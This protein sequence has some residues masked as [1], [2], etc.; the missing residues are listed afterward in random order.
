M[1]TI[2]CLQLL[3]TLSKLCLKWYKNAENNWSP[4]TYCVNISSQHKCIKYHR[5]FMASKA[6]LTSITN[7]VELRCV[8]NEKQLPPP[9]S[10]MIWPSSRATLVCLCNIRS[11]V[12]SG[13]WNRKVHLTIIHWNTSSCYSSV[14][15]SSVGRAR[16]CHRCIAGLIPGIDMWDGNGH[17]VEQG[18]CFLSLCF[19]GVTDHT[20]STVMSLTGRK[21]EERPPEQKQLVLCSI[22]ER[23]HKCL[24]TNMKFLY[25]KTRTFICTKSLHTWSQ[26]FQN[27][28]Q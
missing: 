19:R 24:S 28:A 18:A 12:L 21:T 16:A 7:G 3:H 22:G 15:V 8:P 4:T 11:L 5:S 26:Y 17:Y 23:G 2:K 14:M 27:Q 20:Q 1:N 13:V 10:N 6:L 25:T 9:P